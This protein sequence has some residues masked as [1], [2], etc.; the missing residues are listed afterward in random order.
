MEATNY[1]ETH[2][3]DDVYHK[4]ADGAMKAAR[5]SLFEKLQASRGGKTE[6]DHEGMAS[7]LDSITK[8]KMRREIFC[9]MW[10]TIPEPP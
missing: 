10:S 7:Y 4:D 2:N 9:F 5:I 6:A 3:E 1:E 8:D